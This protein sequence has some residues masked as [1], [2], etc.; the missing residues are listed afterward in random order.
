MRFP[1]IKFFRVEEY[2]HKNIT[3]EY[4]YTW[5]TWLTDKGYIDSNRTDPPKFMDFLNQQQN[6]IHLNFDYKDAF[7]RSYPEPFTIGRT[8]N[9]TV[10]DNLPRSPVLEKDKFTLWIDDIENPIFV[11]KL[12]FKRQVHFVD[13]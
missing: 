12:G 8:I 4:I 6:I 10:D 13:R 2:F 11:E 5:R 1:N 9:I 3:V 7:P